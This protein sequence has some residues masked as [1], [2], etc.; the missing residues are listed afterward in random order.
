MV[1]EMNRRQF[2]KSSVGTSLGLLASQELQEASQE[3][4]ERNYSVTFENGSGHSRLR[5]DMDYAVFKYESEYNGTLNHY[6]PVDLTVGALENHSIDEL[7]N[8]FSGVED[9]SEIDEI[10]LYAEDNDIEPVEA[11]LNEYDELRPVDTGFHI[12]Y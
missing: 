4:R 1:E 7:V 6:L 5:D 8:K 3:R 2:V 10:E 12:K 11:S 9:V